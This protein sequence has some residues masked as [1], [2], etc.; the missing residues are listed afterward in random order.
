M[1]TDQKLIKSKSTGQ[2]LEPQMSQMDADERCLSG[3]GPPQAAPT[4]AHAYGATLPRTSDC[5]F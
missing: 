4:V 2:K 3:M 1:N 5:R